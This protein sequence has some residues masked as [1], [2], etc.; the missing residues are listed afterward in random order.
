[1]KRWIWR[2]LNQEWWRIPRNCNFS[3]APRSKNG[4]NYQKK[5]TIYNIL[6]LVLHECGQPFAFASVN[7]DKAINLAFKFMISLLPSQRLTIRTQRIHD[8]LITIA[9]N[10]KCNPLQIWYQYRIHGERNHSFPH[11]WPR[12]CIHEEGFGCT[13][14]RVI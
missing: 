10:K 9:T 13:I 8:V 14:I 6:W 11:S 12:V 2:L 3:K 4:E 5:I 7:I 1:M